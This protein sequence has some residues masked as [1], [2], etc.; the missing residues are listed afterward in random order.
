MQKYSNVD[1]NVLN[2]KYN[3]TQA[4]LSLFRQPAVS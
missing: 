4:R 3:K 1:I 2:A